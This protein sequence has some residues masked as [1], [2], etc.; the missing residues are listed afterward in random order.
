[1]LIHERVGPMKQLAN[2]RA[3][4]PK[5]TSVTGMIPVTLKEAAPITCDEL[6]CVEPYA[7]KCAAAIPV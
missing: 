5:T 3:T 2:I 1:V 4:N 7:E 6:T